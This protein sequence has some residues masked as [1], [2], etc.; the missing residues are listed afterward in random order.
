VVIDDPAAPFGSD[1]VV[2]RP[3]L[4]NRPLRVQLSEVRMRR[5]IEV[6][7]GDSV[8]V[9]GMESFGRVRAYYF[10]SDEIPRHVSWAIK[11]A[12]AGCARHKLRPPSESRETANPSP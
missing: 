7:Q 11:L 10:M 2:N 4:S 3:D 12:L 5:L 1:F 6:C 8:A 9:V